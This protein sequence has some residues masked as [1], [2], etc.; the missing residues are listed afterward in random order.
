MIPVWWGRVLFIFYMYVALINFFL[1]Q[2]FEKLHI[3]V[4][5]MKIYKIKVQDG[6][7]IWGIR[8]VNTCTQIRTCVQLG[9]ASTGLLGT[10][11]PVF[12]GLSK[13]I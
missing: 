5:H 2:L 13:T 12:S 7:I 1:N 6:N 4:V 8:S 9:A 10:I 11:K 3:L